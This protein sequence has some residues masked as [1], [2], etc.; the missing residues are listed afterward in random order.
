MTM[1]ISAVLLKIRK[2]RTTA[3]AVFVLPDQTKIYRLLS[4]ARKIDLTPYLHDVQH[5]SV[6]GE[7]GRDARVCSYTWVLNIREQCVTAGV[8]FW[9]KSTGT[10]FE[11]DGVVEKINHFKQGALAKELN[12]DISDG[13]RLF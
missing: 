3:C 8:T 4:H 1:S 10:F 11:R 2:W 7:N 13:K 12:I 9:F 5:I 6:S